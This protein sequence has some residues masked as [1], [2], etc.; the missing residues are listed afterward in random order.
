MKITCRFD[1]VDVTGTVIDT[2]RAICVQPFVMAEGYVMFEVSYGE[3][4]YNWKGKYF[5]ETPATAI[6][7]IRFE[8][9]DV[10]ERSPAEIKISWNA[11]NLTTNLNAPITISLW[12]YRETTIRPERLYI[13]VI[14]VTRRDRRH[15]PPVQAT[16]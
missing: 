5:I 16:G 8:T 3:T 1:T 11:Q 9:R 10:H 4:R 2:N 12:G 15:S 13:D 14:E 7:R 6:E